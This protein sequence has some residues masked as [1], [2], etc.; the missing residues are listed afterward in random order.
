MQ[1][2]FRN[3]EL[4]EQLAAY[5]LRK[6]PEFSI[7]VDPAWFTSVPLA[8]AIKAVRKKRVGYG[9][10]SSLLLDLRKQKLI[11]DDEE[12]YSAAL[13]K[14]FSVSIGTLTPKSALVL[15][16]Q[17]KDLADGR[18]LFSSL[19]SV[20]KDLKNFDLRKA[21]EQLRHLSRHVDFDD[22]SGG[23]WV[24]SY[25]RRVEIVK[26]NLKRSQETE[27][28]VSGIPTGLVRFDKLTQ[29]VAP[30][31]FGVVLART[32]LGKTVLLT[33]FSA[34]AYVSGF[35]VMFATGEMSK[36]QIEFRLDANL[37][38]VPLERFRSGELTKDHWRMWKRTIDQYK[39]TQTN[40]LHVCEFSRH[41]S[42]ADI[43]S[44]ALRI[45]DQHQ[46]PIHAIFVDYLNIMNPSQMHRG[47]SREWTSQADVVWEIKSLAEEFN[48]GIALWTGGQVKSDSADSAQ[49][50]AE[51]GKYAGAISETAPIVVG[52]VQTQEDLLQ[53]RMQFQVLKIR[54]AGKPDKVMYLHPNLQLARL[55]EAI[56]A[57]TKDLRVLEDDYVEPDPPKRRSQK[58]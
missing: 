56:V 10:A 14:L 18:H 7:T 44:A 3:I 41:F 13:K 27:T 54:N 52:L 11:I 20:V 16:E 12:V 39:S 15:A 47:G 45:Q 4:E 58:R 5:V 51:S 37:A 49:L 35:N 40:F 32:G 36:T 43:E 50:T 25:G 21:K 33:S 57:K 53:K 34:F 9:S 23:D 55:H 38:G 8:S 46:A 1:P 42:V 30:G 24:D 2:K 31:E 26:G 6:A 48:G 17:V 22:G 29:G 19:R 28:G